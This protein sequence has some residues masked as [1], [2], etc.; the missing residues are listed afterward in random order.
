MIYSSRLDWFYLSDDALLDDIV[1]EIC[2]AIENK[3]TSYRRI[4]NDIRQKEKQACNLILNAL[5]LGFFSIPETWVSI[6]LRPG[7]YTNSNYNYRS[8]KKI[9]D[10]LKKNKF[11]KV[12]L[13]SE[14]AKRVTRILPTKKLQK[15]FNGLGFKWRHYHYNNNHQPIILKDKDKIPKKVPTNQET[16]NYRNN[17]NK[18]NKFL[19]KHCIALDLKDKQLEE[20]KKSM[21]GELKDKNK[22]EEYKYSLNFSKVTLCR[23]F[24]KNNLKLGG[25]FYRGWW[26]SVPKKF[27][28]HITID[29]YKTSEVDYS[30]MSLRILYSKENITIPDNKDLYDIGLVGSKSYLKNAREL[31]K[32]YTNAILNDTKG[33]FRLDNKKL[34]ILKLSHKELKDKVFN[35]HRPIS[36][37]FSTGIGLETMFTD[38]QIAENIMLHYLKEGIVVL[39][40][41][42]SFIIRA[43]FELDLNN[44]M[45]SIFYN[46][47]GSG[48]KTKS[49]GPLLPKH[50]NKPTINKI[51]KPEDDIVFG[52]KLGSLVLKN[53]SSIYEDYLKSW[54]KWRTNNQRA[55]SYN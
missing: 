26:Q 11:I 10:F 30:T 44:T 53:E 16:I 50:F 21:S 13:G 37:Y 12:K 5:Y 38:S 23:I 55:Y 49:T 19:L 51:N 18:I 39:P 6:P 52:S 1:N 45:I 7:A 35:A 22:E 48:T 9:Y 4:N 31:V 54:E 15:K 8:I 20:L 32:E 40:I 43:G 27:R 47:V 36:K 42:D 24:S 29:G 3:R 33:T 34:S 17:L 14:Y 41:H 2:V 25:R 46:L 28:P